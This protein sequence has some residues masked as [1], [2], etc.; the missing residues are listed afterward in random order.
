MS[1]TALIWLVALAWLLW[2]QVQRRQIGGRGG[3][4][5]G[6]RQ[7]GVVLLVIGAVE[8]AGFAQRSHL[9]ALSIAIL[10]V[11]F[12][13]GAGLG[14]VR[15]F[16]VRLWVEDGRLLRQGTAITVL[17]W[18][19]A[20]GLHLG[21]DYTVRRAGGPAGAGSAS[22]LLY[23]GLAFTVQSFVLRHRARATVDELRGR[24]VA[25]PAH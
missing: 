8:F 22:M 13:V 6:R 3:R 4:G 24:R 14:A 11:S 7:V 25:A 16:T 23:L 19:V 12:A 9:T 18:L 17:L 5:G 21:S 10:G 20:V 2:R 15:A 1:A